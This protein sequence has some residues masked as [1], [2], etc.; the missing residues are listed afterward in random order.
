MVSVGY[1]VD[2]IATTTATIREVLGTNRAGIAFELS[3][4]H[5]A[6]PDLVRGRIRAAVKGADPY[7][8]YVKISYYGGAYLE[9]SRLAVMECGAAGIVG[10]NSLG[11]FPDINGVLA[12]G[13]AGWLSG[14]LMAGVSLQICRE[15]SELCDRR[16]VPYIAVGGMND[17][18]IGA[19]FWAGASAV[20][21]CTFLMAHGVE[22][23]LARLTR[24]LETAVLRAG[25]TSVLD[26]RGMERHNPLD[27]AAEMRRL[28]TRV[29]ELTRN[30]IRVAGLQGALVVHVNPDTCRGC[31]HCAPEDGCSELAFMTLDRGKK[32]ID[33]ERCER[34]GACLSACHF[35]AIGFQAL[36]EGGVDATRHIPGDPS[37]PLGRSGYSS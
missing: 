29:A 37:T 8:L 20:A 27:L 4:H 36:L 31:S 7:P 23:G 22:R 18:N 28:P 17:K 25:Q 6:H 12:P 5:A 11:P 19:Y 24:G 15:V 14:N 9:M 3:L 21:A 34:C 35:G 26:I 30:A 2:E 1:E 32:A 33:S 13:E 16:G 10:I